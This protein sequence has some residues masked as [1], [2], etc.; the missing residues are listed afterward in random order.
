MSEIIQ[1]NSCE[2][3]PSRFNGIRKLVFSLRE[4]FSA[5]VHS[6]R[7]LGLFSEFRDTTAN[8]L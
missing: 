2:G 7:G 6:F 5:S 8:T 3:T 1:F 4:M